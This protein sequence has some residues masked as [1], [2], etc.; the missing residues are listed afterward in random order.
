[1]EWTEIQQI[2]CLL[3]SILLGVVLGLLFELFT[4]WV[5]LSQSP[6]VKFMLDTLY[7]AASG[8]VTFFSALIIT[9]GQMHPLLF[10]G[11]FC[12]FL[13]EHYSMGRFFSRGIYRIMYQTGKGLRRV[14]YLCDRLLITCYARAC[15]IGKCWY[16]RFFT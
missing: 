11:S 7:G 1:M 16:Q 3:Q 14:L 2:I 15:A 9:D 8:V 12:G 4:A 5:R 13:C 10:F 6:V